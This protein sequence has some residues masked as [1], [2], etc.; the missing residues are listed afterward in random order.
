MMVGISVIERKGPEVTGNVRV[1][2]H[3]TGRVAVSWDGGVWSIHD[4]TENLRWPA[5]RTGHEEDVT[6]QGWVE[7]CVTLPPEP[8]HL[9][10]G[11]CDR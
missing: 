10:E 11:R 5:V 3:N 9:G 1:R 2:V 7:L 6:G 8:D 4:G